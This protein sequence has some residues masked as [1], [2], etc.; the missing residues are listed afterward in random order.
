M[1]GILFA[2][3]VLPEPGGPIMIMLCPPADATSAALLAKNCPLI[4]AKS[5]VVDNSS[6]CV[7]IFPLAKG[8][9]CISF[10]KNLLFIFGFAH[11]GGPY[12]IIKL[13]ENLGFTV[14]KC[15]LLNKKNK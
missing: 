13:L 15:D 3:I 1:V 10:F 9:F 14:K 11:L 4:S 12:G 7:A 8:T 6:G 5:A 2:I